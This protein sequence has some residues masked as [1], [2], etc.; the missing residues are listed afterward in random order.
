[1]HVRCQQL[2]TR[3]GRLLSIATGGRASS[4]R[5][6]GAHR[7][8]VHGPAARRTSFNCFAVCWMRL[9]SLA[10]CGWS[11]AALR[12]RASLM[13]VILRSR[14]TAFPLA[15]ARQLSRASPNSLWIRSNSSANC[16]HSITPTMSRMLAPRAFLMSAH[17]CA[18]CP[19]AF[20]CCW[21]SP[22]KLCSSVSLMRK[23]GYSTRLLSG[24]MF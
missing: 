15:S 6:C 2:G 16:C 13:R 20:S 10:A 24:K 22:R 18:G 11:S 4:L 12:S 21:A 23:R 17:S 9:R 7:D 14:C 1:M 19:V 3:E 8:R 5:S